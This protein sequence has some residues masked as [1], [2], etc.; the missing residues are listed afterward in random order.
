MLAPQMPHLTPG[1]I[2]RAGGCAGAG[3]AAAAA[4]AAV[5]P[6]CGRARHRRPRLRRLRRV[7]AL[8][9]GHS[10]PSTL[11]AP[12]RASL[13]HLHCV[14]VISICSLSSA[15]AQTCGAPLFLSA[16]LSVT[17]G[18]HGRRSA[19]SFFRHQ[20]GNRHGLQPPPPLPAHTRQP[21]AVHPLL[22]AAILPSFAR[23][24]KSV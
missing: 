6:P 17:P 3:G 16:L 22:L 9:V 23:R 19:V 24:R 20:S 10:L 8:Q 21:T 7:P 2:W 18:R 1:W 12:Q 11:H 13:L 4:D 5:L 15:P 14:R